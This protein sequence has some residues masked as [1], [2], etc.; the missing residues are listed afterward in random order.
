MATRRIQ[1][2]D[3]LPKPDTKAFGILSCLKTKLNQQIPNTLPRKDYAN[4]IL[5]IWKAALYLLDSNHPELHQE[6]AR[7]LVAK[8]SYGR[9]YI[10]QTV[11]HISLSGQHSV[12]VE[13]FILI[14]AHP[15]LLNCPA[16]ESCV[17]GIY[18][19]VAGE[20]G[21]HGIGFLSRACISRLARLE[22]YSGTLSSEDYN[23][24]SSIARACHELACRTPRIQTRNSRP[25]FLVP[26]SK[27]VTRMDEKFPKTNLGGLHS[28]L[29]MVTRLVSSTS[30]HLK[31]A[32]TLETSGDG[33]C[34][35]LPLFSIIA[36]KPG[37]RHDN[38]FADISEIFIFPTV[39]EIKRQ[40]AV[41]LPSTNFLDTHALED[42][43][44][45]YIDSMFRLLR[46]DTIG[47]VIGVLRELL[48]SDDPMAGRLYK[49][50]LGA[51]VYKGCTV[52]ALYLDTKEGPHAVLSFPE[53]LNIT[54]KPTQCQIRWWIN[55]T[56]L[57]KGRLLCFVSSEA[58]CQNILFFQ[59]AYKHVK[60][61]D[62][63][64]QKSSKDCLISDGESLSITAKLVCPQRSSF[65]QLARLF[66]N[67][68]S[69]VLVD[70]NGILPE[71]FL[72]VFKNLQRIRLDNHLPFY[73]WLVPTTSE[74]GDIPPPLYA[75]HAGFTFPLG[76]IAK[77]HGTELSLDP[78]IEFQRADLT[79]LAKHTGLDNG[80]CQ[81]LVAAL[82]R[83]YALIQGPP[84]TGKSYLGVQ[85][86]RVLLAVREQAKLG[87]IVV[88]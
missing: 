73:K 86:V 67:K 55:S 40:H 71:T 53:S 30:T 16:V 42:P 26:L 51:D 24:I 52:D 78:T 37:G 70:F 57:E 59:A 88:W 44:R 35:D 56:R 49:N 13:T 34:D 81:G 12:C 25:A 46:H 72:P 31:G 3:E 11:Q 79:E 66:S 6:V 83:E 28:S 82:S 17:Q 64:C 15:S 77:N 8:S 76:C 65:S 58:G 2:Q 75:R 29:D 43:L 21:E 60:G 20:G 62:H 45:R 23:L 61:A 68:T 63:N 10:V 39:D 38:D 84:G 54:D 9:K 87:P 80:Q 48:G 5:E 27:L 14:L 85:L 69:G 47:P 1:P 19:C 33:P 4:A 74:V 18:A 36:D 41:Y 32:G 7:E 50:E 22:K